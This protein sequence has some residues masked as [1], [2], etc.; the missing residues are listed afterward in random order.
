L[1]TAHISN[2]FMGE[3]GMVWFFGVVEDVSDPLFAGRVRV[4]CFGFH[5]PDKSLIPTESLPWA[6]VI[7]PAT[8]ASI[9]GVGQTPHGLVPGSHV[10]GF[11]QDGEYA[12]YPMIL[13]TVSGVPQTAPSP[14]DGFSDPT[15]EFPRYTGQPDTNTLARND[16]TTENAPSLARKRESRRVD[17]PTASGEIW[18]ERETPYATVYPNNQV[19][20]TRS[21]IILEL[22]DTPDAERINLEHPSGSFV[23]YHP[24]G[25]KVEKTKGDH[26]NFTEGVK[27][28]VVTGKMSLTVE[29]TGEVLI[30]DT[31]IVKV[32]NNQLV[33]EVAN[34]NLNLSVNGDVY[35]DITGDV[36]QN[37]Q[38]NVNSTI[39]GDRNEVVGGN[40][41]IA[42]SG[43]INMRGAAIRLN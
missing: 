9:S 13:G 25:S 12:Q 31:M 35:A 21:G 6:Q 41:N 42:A 4:R 16:E 36:E 38:G 14:S 1:N 20:E 23:E 19:I 2:Q 32:E 39:N 37:I 5:N 15:G 26:Q 17:I 8:G 27:Q 43:S 11:F 40:Y 22:D 30:N 3:S 7:L 28:E 34:G 29:N 33:I 18:S 24:D 10:M